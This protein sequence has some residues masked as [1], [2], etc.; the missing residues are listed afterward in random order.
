MAKLT[1][2]E[3]R[4]MEF[5]KK[6]RGYDEKFVKS[7]LEQVAIQMEELIRE[8]MM[9]KE[10]VKDY[11]RVEETLRS[12]LQA[13]EKAAGEIKKNAEREAEIIIKEAKAQAENIIKNAKMEQERLQREIIDLKTTKDKL[14]M[15]MRTI[16]ETHIKLLET[17]EKKGGY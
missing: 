15:E 16:L 3:I 12:T 10:K 4:N 5:P 13:A 8:N 11:E 9:L 2:M 7:F 1:P 17:Y 14:L 6:F